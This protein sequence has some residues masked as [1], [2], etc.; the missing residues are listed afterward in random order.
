LGLDAAKAGRA[1]VVAAADGY[2]SFPI[3]TA[4]FRLITTPE[5]ARL[6]VEDF[7]LLDES[8]AFADYTKT[9][10][11][12]GEIYVMNAQHSWHARTKTLLA[13]E[14]NLALRA[15]GSD[16]EAWAE[17]STRVSDF[18]LPEPD[19]VVTRHRGRGVVPLE[20]VALLVEVSDTTLDID[21]GRKLRIYAE[22]GVPEYWVVDL[23]G[24]T[25]I[26]LWEPAGA[27]YARRDEV[28]LGGLVESAT[29][30][31]LAARAER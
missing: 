21:L 13:V 22:A 7:L 5:K 1:A 12:E 11:I 15:M 17:P 27:D 3:M 28:A 26:R 4:P 18:S 30:T 9:E 2:A 19:V 24:G 25:L 23:N 14:L 20:S 29:I 10:L 31:G 6:R 16:L 8:G